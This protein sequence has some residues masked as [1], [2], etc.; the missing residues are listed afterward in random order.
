MTMI[1]LHYLNRSRAKRILWLLEEIGQPYETVLYQRDA[2]TSLAP[3]E[4]KLVHPLGKSPVIEIDGICLAESGA[5]TEYLIERFAPERLAP[6]RGSAEYAEYLQ[7]IHFAESSAMLP[8]L[9]RMFI[10]RDG[11]TTHGLLDYAQH[12]CEQVLN[13]LNQQM[14]GKRY[15]VGERLSGADIMM[16]FIMDI[17]SLSGSL[18][19]Y[20]N[21]ARFAEQLHTHPAW[22]KANAFEQQCTS[23]VDGSLAHGD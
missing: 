6:A 10:L 1:K 17:L 19:R 4:L 20:P 22:R 16:S 8:L 21:L 3:P 18:E 2:K 15:W 11:C 7:W 9:L 5:I 13:Y 23:S 14:T 12:E